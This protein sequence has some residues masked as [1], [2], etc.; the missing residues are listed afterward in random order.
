[1][2]KRGRKSKG[3]NL[4][5][6][7]S[8]RWLYTLIAI[9][10]ISILG[11]VVYAY[12]T[13]NPSAFGHSINELERC[14]SGQMLRTSGGSWVC[15][16]SNVIIYRMNRACETGVFRGL[17]EPLVLRPT[18]FVETWASPQSSYGCTD[19]GV[20]QTKREPSCTTGGS[21]TCSMLFT[22]RIYQCP[23][24]PI[25]YLISYS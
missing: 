16:N 22:Y 8:N 25:G 6:H 10:I 19:L 13:S 15:T 14:S 21:P 7:L 20:T 23:N 3:L 12:G 17:T 5:I 2:K 11:V 4:H 9:G 24:T 18:C 1:M